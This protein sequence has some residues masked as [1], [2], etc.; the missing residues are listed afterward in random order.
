[1]LRNAAVIRDEIDNG[2]LLRATGRQ[3]HKIP[4]RQSWK[5]LPSNFVRGMR[6]GLLV[7]SYSFIELSLAPP[8]NTGGWA[9][10]PGQPANYGR[11]VAW[12]KSAAHVLQLSDKWGF[13]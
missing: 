7:R 11:P 9:W 6:A 4:V 1:M 10:Q 3:P 5:T 12:R 2:H 13:P 8:P